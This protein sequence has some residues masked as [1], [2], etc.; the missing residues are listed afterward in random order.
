MSGPVA[1]SA[2]RFHWAIF[3]SSWLSLNIDLGCQDG[4]NSVSVDLSFCWRFIGLS[5][6][7]NHNHIQGAAQRP[8]RFPRGIPAW[9]S[10]GRRTNASLALWQHEPG[11][12]T[13]LGFRSIWRPDRWYSFVSV[14]PYLFSR[15]DLMMNLSHHQQNLATADWWWQSEL[16][17]KIRLWH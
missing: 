8:S 7:T 5:I 14:A 9:P 17:E 11:C 16:A 4:G 15:D 12:G 3:S 1:E 13:E 10:G 6:L 2:Y